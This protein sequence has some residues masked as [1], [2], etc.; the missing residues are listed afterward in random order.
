MHFAYQ[1]FILSILANLMEDL[2]VKE[3]MVALTEM[4]DRAKVEKEV[5]S[6]EA[7][8]VEVEKISQAGIK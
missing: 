7:T 5:A 8:V 3:E 4:G 6:E 2:F 1:P